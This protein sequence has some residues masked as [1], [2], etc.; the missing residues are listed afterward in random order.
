MGSKNDTN[1][2]NSSTGFSIGFI[3]ILQLIFITLKLLGKISWSW[4]WVLTPMWGQAV[5]LA[6]V[7]VVAI[8]CYILG[9]K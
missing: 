2:N 9:N 6:I 7:L 8:I 3:G 4:W 5:V 1:R